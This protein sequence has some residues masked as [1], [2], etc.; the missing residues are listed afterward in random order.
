MVAVQLLLLLLLLQFQHKNLVHKQPAKQHEG[1]LLFVVRV[2]R[3]Q[4]GKKTNKISHSCQPKTTYFLTRF[5]RALL[6]ITD[7][8]YGLLLPIIYGYWLA[9]KICVAQKTHTFIHSFVRTASLFNHLFIFIV[10]HFPLFFKKKFH[11]HWGSLEP[12][13]EEKWKF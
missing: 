3:T 13:K 4:R 9:Y 8:N 5:L 2:S 11:V 7:C 1:I 12:F 10:S 6:M